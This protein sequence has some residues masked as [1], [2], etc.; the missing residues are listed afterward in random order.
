MKIFR[1]ALFLSFTALFLACHPASIQSTFVPRI[2]L[3]SRCEIIFSGDFMQHLP[4]VSAAQRDTGFDYLSSLKTIIPY[5]KSADFAVINL[6]TTLSP[7]PP[8]TG[9][10]MFRSPS[11]IAGALKQAGITHVALANNHAMDKGLLGARFT[12]EALQR[13]GLGYCGVR[14]ANDG[15][16]ELMYLCKNKFKIAI[17]NYTYSANGMP[18]PRGV[19]LNMIDTVLIKGDI[20]LARGEGA[21]HIVAFFHWGDEYSVRASRAQQ[22]LAAW[23]RVGG[24][25]VVVGSH[26]HVVQQIDPAGQTIYSLGNFV[27][28]QRERYKNGGISV[29]V[30]F[31][32]GFDR[33]TFAFLPHAVG[34]TYNIILPGQDSSNLSHAD[35]R[36]AVNASL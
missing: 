11:A 9:Y 35:S 32:E 22:E 5:W 25:N 19:Q 16:A 24:V 23:C 31:Y 12:I 4:Q 20:A 1:T 27:S 15:R 2:D 21:S 8:Y 34:P 17:L 3:P 29:R 7:T 13:A 18:V 26:P 30:T 10:P 33:A 28:N 6:E 36:R 14:L